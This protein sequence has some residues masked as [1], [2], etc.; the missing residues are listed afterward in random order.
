VE[1]VAPA[2]GKLGVMVVGFGAVATTMIAGVESVPCGPA[3]QIGSLTKM[4]T[5][6]LSKR[7]DNKTSLIKDF[8]PLTALND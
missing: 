5:I 4:G 7:A 8:V 6:R 1:Q 2:T 3:K